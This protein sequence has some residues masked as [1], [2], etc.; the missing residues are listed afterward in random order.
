MACRSLIPPATDGEGQCRAVAPCVSPTARRGRAGKFHAAIAP[1]SP[2][3]RR[4][5]RA[6]PHHLHRQ[7]HIAIAQDEHVACLFRSASPPTAS[8]RGGCGRAAQ[9]LPALAVEGKREER[10]ARNLPASCARPTRRRRRTWCGSAAMP[11]KRWLW[12]ASH[13]PVLR[14]DINTSAYGADGQGGEKTDR[15]GAAARHFFRRPPGAAARHFSRRAPGTTDRHFF[16]RA[17]GAL[18]LGAMCRR[19]AVFVLLTR[20]RAGG[21]AL[22]AAEASAAWRGTAPWLQ[23]PPVRADVMDRAPPP[24]GPSTALII[25]PCAKNPL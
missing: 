2:S 20:G 23:R 4:W 12:R 1:L 22:A 17:P 10:A 5:G 13:A 16:R 3:S 8:A 24:P 25:Q 6:A 9:Q 19:P 7:R 21:S 11:S 14:D 15:S 18:R